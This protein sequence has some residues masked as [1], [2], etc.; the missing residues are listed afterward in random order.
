MFVGTDAACGLV[1]PCVG[2]VGTRQD[3]YVLALSLV[4]ALPYSNFLHTTNRPIFHMLSRKSHHVRKAR[5]IGAQKGA[6]PAAKGP[7]ITKKTAL[8]PVATRPLPKT[9]E[10]DADHLPELPTYKPPLYLKFE[11][12]EPP[13]IGL[14][15]L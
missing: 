4:L 12:S 5:T 8:K 2:Q 9:V 3:Y 7:K 1:Y 10:F 11:A 14:T 15:E 6:P 13:A